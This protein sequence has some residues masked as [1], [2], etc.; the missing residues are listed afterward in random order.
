M[1]CVLRTRTHTHTHTSCLNLIYITAK[2]NTKLYLQVYPT[3]SLLPYFSISMFHITN[4]FLI[5]MTKLF[6]F[7]TKPSI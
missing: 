2:Y 4:Q 3:T 7:Y 1:E 6:Y 5:I